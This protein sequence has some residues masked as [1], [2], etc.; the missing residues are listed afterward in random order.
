M[1]R[2]PICQEKLEKSDRQF[3]C[4]NHHSFDIA[5]QGY[6]NL[7]LKQ[8]K[9]QGDN[10]A[11][12]QARTHFLEKDYYAFMRQEVLDLLKKY[13]IHSLI[14]LGCGQ[15]Y[16]TSMFQSVCDPCFGVD[17]SKEAVLYAAKQ[18]KKIQYLVASIYDLPFEDAC[19]DGVTSI[20]VGQADQEVHRVL[21]DQGVWITVGPGPRHCWELK[22][23]LYQTVLENPEEQDTKE[24]FVLV[25]KKHIQKQEKVDELW[26]LLEMTPYRY[27]SPKAG[28]EAVKNCSSLDVTFEFVIRCWRKI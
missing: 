16:Y 26:N 20:F 10:K 2:C 4:P 1:L 17:L 23:K 9:N 11:M 24:R 12:V 6:V 27:K 3:V 7:S 25:E 14:D 21:K 8:K 5:K 13:E 19:C 22:E 28:L 15:G 18:N